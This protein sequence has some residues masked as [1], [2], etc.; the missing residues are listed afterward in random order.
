M[1]PRVFEH[2]MP[3]FDC[4]IVARMKTGGASSIAMGHRGSSPNTASVSSNCRVAAGLVSADQRAGK[5]GLAFCY[6]TEV[7]CGCRLS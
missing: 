4:L 3:D 1:A 6:F 7:G 5:V 2:C